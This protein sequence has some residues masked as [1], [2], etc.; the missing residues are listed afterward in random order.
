M[1]YIDT[2]DQEIKGL[3]FYLAEEEYVARHILTDEDCLF[4]WHV[5]PTV[6]FGRNQVVEN[7]VNME[8]CRQEGI[9]VIQRHSGGGCVF[10]DEDC[11]MISYITKETRPIIA[12]N[13]Y[14][15]LITGALNRLGIAAKR[16][17]HNDIMLGEHK[18]SG[19]AMWSH[20]NTTI[21]HGTLLY[22]TNERHITQAI[23]P[24]REKLEKN[25][26]KSV[27]QRI[28][29]LKD[30]T[31]L[32]RDELWEKLRQAL[33]EKTIVLGTD[34]IEEI[35]RQEKMKYPNLAKL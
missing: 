30:H 25:G 21:V 20:G 5:H 22:D 27:R 12:F 16:N 33:C 19:N 1:Y 29:L 3:G 23:T 28:A 10:A 26:V 17:D 31:P 7:E 14:M 13:N 24:T 15:E 34:D 18:I 4:I 32:T 9:R 8:Y 35:I 2:T 11:L 6:I